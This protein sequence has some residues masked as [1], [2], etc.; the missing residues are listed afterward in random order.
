MKDQIPDNQE[1]FEPRNVAVIGAS[2]EQKKIGH[3]NPDKILPLR[4]S[5][6]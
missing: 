4:I 6:T 3:I 5:S 1:L 2:K